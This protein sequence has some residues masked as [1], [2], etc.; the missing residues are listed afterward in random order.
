MASH[1]PCLSPSRRQKTLWLCIWKSPHLNWEEWV[2]KEREWMDGCNKSNDTKLEVCLTAKG[3]HCL[4]TTTHV[5]ECVILHRHNNSIVLSAPFL[6]AIS[7]PLSSLLS[8][9]HFGFPFKIDKNSFVRLKYLPP[10]PSNQ[11]IKCALFPIYSSSPLMSQICSE[12]VPQQPRPS[13]LHNWVC[14][15]PSG[16][17]RT[18]RG[19]FVASAHL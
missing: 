18:E 3:K 12:R 17:W 13:D 15:P 19:W 2:R 11:C 1:Y 4:Q 5:S 14:R 6:F 16:W 7:V 9:H 10:P 8:S